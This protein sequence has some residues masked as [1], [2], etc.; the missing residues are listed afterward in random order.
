MKLPLAARQKKPLPE[1]ILREA[2]PKNR[3]RIGMQTAVLRR[4]KP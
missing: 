1:N 3:L 2:Y 4:C